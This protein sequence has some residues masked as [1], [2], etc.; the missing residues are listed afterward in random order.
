[1]Y[2]LVHIPSLLQNSLIWKDIVWADENFEKTSSFDKFWNL[3][4]FWKKKEKIISRI[5]N[6]NDLLKI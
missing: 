2:F 6:R 4:V 1:M 3:K 5:F